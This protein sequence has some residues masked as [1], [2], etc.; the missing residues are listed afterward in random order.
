MIDA[1]NQLIIG[2][3][4]GTFRSLSRGLIVF[5]PIRRSDFDASFSRI[6]EEITK[7]CG[8]VDPSKN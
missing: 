8:Q 7:R 2:G 6:F 3:K 5:N 1:I 4:L